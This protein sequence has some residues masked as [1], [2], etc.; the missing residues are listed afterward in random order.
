[1]LYNPVRTLWVFLESTSSFPCIHHLQTCSTFS[2]VY[3]LRLVV[4]ACP[5][6]HS[7]P[8]WRKWR[9]QTT[10]LFGF[11]ATQN[12]FSFDFVGLRRF[13]KASHLREQ[14]FYLGQLHPS[15]HTVCK[16]DQ[17][18]CYRLILRRSANHFAWGLRFGHI[19]ETLSRFLDLDYGYPR[20][21]R[22]PDYGT[23]D[24]SSRPRSFL[25]QQ[26]T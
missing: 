24:I 14:R 5:F 8:Y 13:N 12:E 7:I 20:R 19:W 15:C 23:K 18:R 16:L 10:Y 6:W 21:I 4:L 1:M 17:C 25:M 11:W 9:H 22:W 2:K 3:Q 26:F